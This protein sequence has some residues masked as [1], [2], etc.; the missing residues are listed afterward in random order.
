MDDEKIKPTCFVI[1]SFDG[2]KY[3]RRYSETIRPALI[4]AGVEP[5]RADEILGLNPVIE[6]IE[7]AIDAASICIAEV[8]EDNP[9]VWLELGYALALDR[10][11]VIL[12]DKSKRDKLPFDIQYR[13]IIF[14]RTDS[15]SGYEELEGNIIKWIKNELSTSQ[16]IRSIKVLKLGSE[17]KSDLE[18][19]EVA[20]LSSAFAFWPT[21]EGGISHW[22]L[23]QNLKEME[24]TEIALALG[25]SG[26]I[27]RNFLTEKL[28]IDHDYQNEGY[29]AYFITNSGI[30]WLQKNKDS[31]VVKQ[32]KKEPEPGPFDIDIPF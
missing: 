5:Q 8:S 25:V 19:Y 17:T 1:Q 27:E 21:T 29:K 30:Q 15:R 3:D 26:L 28:L 23:E 6:K 2:G 4:K 31:L 18:D 12:C 24:F 32:P 10:P 22:K 14:Y 9:N 7:T 11:T 16:R 13:P 20:V